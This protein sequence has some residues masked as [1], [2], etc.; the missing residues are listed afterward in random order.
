VG[1]LTKKVSVSRALAQDGTT[2]VPVL[3]VRSMA[4]KYT[5]CHVRV[6]MCVSVYVCVSHTTGIDLDSNGLHRT[7]HMTSDGM[8]CRVGKQ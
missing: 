8:Q 4:T 7:L 6:S 5:A 3:Y 1:I 2:P